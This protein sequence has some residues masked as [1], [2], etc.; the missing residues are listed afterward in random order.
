MKRRLKYWA[1]RTLGRKFMLLNWKD[2]LS[3][4]WLAVSFLAT[5]VVAEA[6]DERILYTATVSL[7]L[8]AIRSYRV[9]EDLDNPCI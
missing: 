6:E 8:S 7:V 9:M 5:I 4:I 2:K 1:I 3:L